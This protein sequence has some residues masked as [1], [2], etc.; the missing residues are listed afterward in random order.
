MTI[1]FDIRWLSLSADG[2]D[3]LDAAGTGQQREVASA[4]SDGRFEALLA[5]HLQ[6]SHTR[7]RALP[8][9]LSSP[10]GMG[11]VKGLRVSAAATGAAMPGDVDRMARIARDVDQQLARIASEGLTV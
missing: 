6:W 2:A 4:P 9:D 11:G 3:A 8:D 10:A 7:L 1:E 5:S